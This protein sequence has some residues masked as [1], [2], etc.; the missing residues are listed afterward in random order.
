MRTI[1]P[2]FWTAQD[3]IRD[4]FDDRAFIGRF[5]ETVVCATGPESVFVF[6]DSQEVRNLA[7]RMALTPIRMRHKIASHTPAYL[8]VGGRESIDHLELVFKAEPDE[9]LILN[10][11]NPLIAPQ[12][13]RTFIQTFRTARPPV[14][15]S[16]VVPVDHPCQLYRNYCAQYRFVHFLDARTAPFPYLERINRFLP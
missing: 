4:H 3:P 12:T 6:T 2:I 7:E 8:P 5:F 1:L 15:M 11:R 9:S 13:I 10:F 14:L 16:G